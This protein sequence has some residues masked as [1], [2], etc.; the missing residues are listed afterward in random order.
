MHNTQYPPIDDITNQNLM[1]PIATGV[2]EAWNSNLAIA[3][4][5]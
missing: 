4:G 3:L 2:G 1:L 5:L